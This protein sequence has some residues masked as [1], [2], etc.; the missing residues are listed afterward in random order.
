MSPFSFV[1]V[2][3]FLERAQIQRILLKLWRA[4]SCKRSK[5]W[6]IFLRQN[7]WAFGDCLENEQTFSD[8]DADIMMS[9][10]PLS[11]KKREAIFPINLCLCRTLGRPGADT[12]FGLFKEFR[13]LD[14]HTNTNTSQ[15]TKILFWNTWNIT[16]I[17]PHQVGEKLG[18]WWSWQM[19]HQ[20]KSSTPLYQQNDDSSDMILAIK[21]HWSRFLA[22]HHSH[23]SNNFRFSIGF[24]IAKYLQ[25]N[26]NLPFVLFSSPTGRTRLTRLTGRTRG[27]GG[28]FQ[29]P[30]LFLCVFS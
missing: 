25:N 2:A 9:M 14:L 20:Y 27:T 21:C 18:G 8:I 26:H 15:Q 5:S 16:P 17:S 6:Q 24:L 19:Y 28:T 13:N 12:S 7:N 4:H 3:P 23:G 22:S 30:K 11:W 1:F 10:L 29:W